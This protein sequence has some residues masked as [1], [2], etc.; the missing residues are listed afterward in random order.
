MNR[1]TKKEE[2]EDQ[3]KS[4][5]SD[6]ND[7]MKT[8]KLMEEDSKEKTKD[9]VK[10]LHPIKNPIKTRSSVDLIDVI[11]WTEKTSDADYYLPP[12]FGVVN[13]QQQL[14]SENYEAQMEDKNKKKSDGY[15]D[16]ALEELDKEDENKRLQREAKENERLQ[17]E[18]EKEQ[19]EIFYLIKKKI[20]K[21]D[22]RG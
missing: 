18:Y 14:E 20:I 2:K 7:S 22:K 15:L 5:N 21:E 13:V 10:T 6:E 17:I 3:D 12:E 11:Q 1:F 4:N 9:E 16:D 19:K 8:G